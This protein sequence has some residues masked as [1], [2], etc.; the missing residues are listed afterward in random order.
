MD[1]Q[2]LLLTASQ[3]SVQSSITLWD[4]N[5]KNTLKSYK[6]GGAVPENCLSVIDQDYI[7]AAEANKPLLHVWPL[8]SQEID[9]TIRYDLFPSISAHPL[10]LHIFTGLY[11]PGR[12]HVSLCVPTTLTWL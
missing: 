2:E 11:Y 1:T 9:K 10:N 4:Y 6:N 7:L 8:N 3:S 5:T 12:L